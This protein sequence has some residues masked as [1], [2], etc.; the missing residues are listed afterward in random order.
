MKHWMFN[1]K[2]MTRVVSESLD[3]D[4]RLFERIG[5]RMH[6]SMCRRCPRFKDQLL[7]IREILRLYAAGEDEREPSHT[8]SPEAR[9]RIKQS[10]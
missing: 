8:L 9:D 1:C 5:L 6:M 2:E 3:R 7:A 10:L 4:L